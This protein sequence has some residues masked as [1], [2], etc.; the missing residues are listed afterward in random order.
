MNLSDAESAA[1]QAENETVRH[2][3]QDEAL[4]ERRAKEKKGE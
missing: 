2:A 4:A 1:Q 3:Q